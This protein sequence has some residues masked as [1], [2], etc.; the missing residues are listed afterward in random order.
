MSIKTANLKTVDGQPMVHLRPSANATAR[1]TIAI[2]SR[3]E[4]RYIEHLAI[5]H[6][7]SDEIPDSFPV[8]TPVGKLQD[9]LIVCTA[10]I[11]CTTLTDRDVV[12]SLVV[13]QKGSDVKNSEQLAHA[14]PVDEVLDAT[15]KLNLK[16]T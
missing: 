6:R 4:S 7:T 13:S 16:V 10:Y 2:W 1:Y 3:T 9:C 5:D 8:T 14:I 15:I 11:G 12:V